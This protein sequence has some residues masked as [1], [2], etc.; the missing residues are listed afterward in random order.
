[1]TIVT[2]NSSGLVLSSGS[3][4]NPIVISQGVTIRNTASTGVGI[5][6]TGST[7]AFTIE[8]YGTVIAGYAIELHGA[9]SSITNSATGFIS[10]TGGGF[11]VRFDVGAANGTVV[12]AGTIRSSNHS[13]VAFLGT[14]SGGFVTNSVGGLITGFTNG[15]YTEGGIIVVNAGSIAGTAVTPVTDGF[16]VNFKFGT[17]S[18]TNMSTGTITGANVGVYGGAT[19]FSN[20]ITNGGQVSGPI[21][22]ELKDGGTVANL[23]A[24]KITGTSFGISIATASGNVTNAGTIR[25]TGSAGI[26]IDVA[27]GGTVSDY[28]AIIGN[29]GTAIY[30]G[31]SA[32]T[33][34]MLVLN[35]GFSISGVVQ[36]GISAS[37]TLQLA[38]GTDGTGTLT[39]LGTEFNNF[40]INVAVNANWVLT[41]NNIMTG[42]SY[43]E[44]ATYLG[45]AG[46]LTNA[47]YLIAE[48][49]ADQ[50]FGSETIAVGNFTNDGT[51]G[52]ANYDDL[53]ITA[54]V[55]TGNGQSGTIVIGHYGIL[56]TETAVSS[57]QTVAFND[58][59][60]ELAVD[61]TADFAGTIAG[62]QIGDTLELN[63]LVFSTD[64]SAVLSGNTLTVTT[65]SGSAQFVLDGV[66]PG[67]RF[68]AQQSG[69]GGV[70]VTMS[71][72]IACFCLG[73]LI[74]TDQGQVPVEDLRIG[75]R[76]VTQSGAT[77]PIR[78]I[79]YRSF[80]LTR[81]PAPERVQP[82]HIAANAFADA[83]PS[84]TLR[85]SPD[86]AVLLDGLLIPAKLLRNDAS[87]VRETTCKSVTYYHVELDAHDVLLAEGLPAESY[88]D[89]GNRSMF[90]NAGRPLLLH[91]AFDNDQV[92][93]ER[94][95]CMPFAAD[96]TRVE[97]VH[98][99]L[100]A[101]AVSL[102]LTS[103]R[104][105]I[106]TD[107]ALC[108]AIGER[109]IRPISHD[110]GRA[111]F[112]L[113]MGPDRVRLVSRSVVPNALNG[114]V[115][116]WRR[117][118]V[119]VVRLTL[120]SAGSV[121]TIPLDHPRLV[122]GWWDI[123]REGSRTWRWSNGDA[124]IPLNGSGPIV[125]EVQLAG[126]LDYPIEEPSPTALCQ[127]HVMAA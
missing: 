81:H 3:F 63:N 70:D 10:A 21:G 61:D 108:V 11:G 1:M 110:S 23:T 52:V 41:G 14:T 38:A 69:D 62:M 7:Q 124:T 2:T 79:G 103:P 97:P 85:L 87:I 84:R 76:V 4:S 106:T 33:N 96:V 50:V 104:Q 94:E 19:A 126:T 35:P 28:G 55:A 44:A 59:T 116:D 29:G 22:I 121:E 82:I 122:G 58:D 39:G 25:A 111:V 95:S 68:I 24:G 75:D 6:T 90:E 42:G 49:G 123:E 93:R 30:F 105:D 83:V 51:I 36:G 45:G 57:G 16:G 120:H 67:S 80:D 89:T 20:H 60:G 72:E 99:R 100:V 92:R 53:S 102:G 64:S 73:T 5:S 46:T 37:N 31:G 18:L 17:N 125:L 107:P 118:G 77:R 91:P 9:D 109:M 54:G 114:W 66:A 119:A 8:N 12:N 48:I 56:E 78:W 43:P 115:D 113:P 34:N 47:G 112:V 40:G 101:R 74:E 127:P 26:A 65:D 32:L 88:L 71:G 98:R 117:L 27:A 13:G 15:V 86:H